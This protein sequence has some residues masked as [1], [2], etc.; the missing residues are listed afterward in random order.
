MGWRH[1]FLAVMA[2]L[3]VAVLWWLPGTLSAGEG[4]TRID[5][6]PELPADR[7]TASLAAITPRSET[8]D[9]PA[10]VVDAQT[11][12]EP[13][14]ATPTDEAPAA[15][16]REA[17]DQSTEP[18]VMGVVTDSE[19]TPL[20]GIE[21]ELADQSS[22]EIDTGPSD[23][24]NSVW[25]LN[26]RPDAKVTSDSLG[27]FA[28]ESSVRAWGGELRF[29]SPEMLGKALV[30]EVDPSLEWQVFRMPVLD[31]QQG[32]WSVEVIDEAG[33]PVPIDGF[34]LEPIKIPADT[35][36]RM[37]LPTESTVEPGRIEQSGLPAGS[38]RMVIHP[39]SNIDVQ[40]EE[41]WSSETNYHHSLVVLESLAD[42]SLTETGPSV[43]PGEPTWIDPASGLLEWLPEDPVGVGE[44]ALNRHF[45]QTLR[46][47]EGPV[48]AAQLT[49]KLRA[50]LHNASNDAIYI[51][52]LGNKR[53]AW[54]SSISK[55]LGRPWKKG[56]TATLRLNLA[57]LPGD[58]TPVDLRPYLED[59]L[60][61]IVVQ[62][63]T[64][65]ESVRVSVYR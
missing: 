58:P 5:D 27:I 11:G 56:S 4:P 34:D 62:D 26:T 42:A 31:P 7:E 28:F 51:E 36:A 18:I 32:I 40:L 45:A 41:T 46:V 2:A 44:Q 48:R 1:G 57:Q 64:T 3:L 17:P 52:H 8:R 53:F 38:W 20:E 47:G 65:I 50:M 43:E 12:P 21:V 63:D 61:D 60:L 54:R 14:A 24:E 55:A 33:R 16:R 29:R 25:I 35:T 13:A 22:F 23:A 10:P 37:P 19:G 30:A 9:V 15:P 6:A 59:G 39:T 49:I